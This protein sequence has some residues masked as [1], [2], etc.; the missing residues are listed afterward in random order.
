[1]TNHQEMNPPAVTPV[2]SV[3][4]DDLIAGKGWQFY[5]Q[6]VRLFVLAILIL[7]IINIA[8]DIY[9]YGHWVIEIFIFILFNLWLILKWRFKLSTNVTASVILGILAGLLLAIFD[10]I[11]YHQFVYLLN[12][13]RQPFILGVE[14]LVISVVFFL[15]FSNLKSRSAESKPKK[16]NLYGGRKKTN[17]DKFR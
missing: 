13:I 16:G 14:G 3:E 4:R 5:W 17:F 7:N 1:M 15:L 2:S 9:V 12:F 8:F 11:W 10:V 6:L